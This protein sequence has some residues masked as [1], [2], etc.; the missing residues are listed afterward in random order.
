MSDTESDYSQS[1]S[2]DSE[3]NFIPGYKITEYADHVA[4]SSDEEGPPGLAYSDEP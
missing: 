3:I 2:D 1:E 4:P